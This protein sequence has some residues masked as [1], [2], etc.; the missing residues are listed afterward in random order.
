MFSR[1]TACGCFDSPSTIGCLRFGRRSRS[2]CR[3]PSRAANPGATALLLWAIFYIAAYTA[4]R[5]DLYR[6]YYTPLVA[7]MAVLAACGMGWA[8]GAARDLRAAAA[9]SA[10]GAGESAGSSLWHLALGLPMALGA[11]VYLLQQAAVASPIIKENIIWTNSLE[12]ARADCARAILERSYSGDVICT[13]AIGIV[14]WATRLPIY[15]RMGLVTKDAVNRDLP[16]QLAVSNARWCVLETEGTTSTTARIAEGYEHVGTFNRG[17]KISFLLYEKTGRNESPAPDPALLADTRDLEL[18]NGLAIRNARLSNRTIRFDLIA[19]RPCPRDYK[20]FV[21]IYRKDAPNG[22]IL[23]I[24][25]FYPMPATSKLTVGTPS[26]NMIM[27]GDD[28]PSEGA[29]VRLGL[30]DELDPQYAPLA[31]ADG[32]IDIRLIHDGS[33]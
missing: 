20:I 22:D 15:D 19:L 14:G 9:S 13:G 24:R 8:W 5:I 17:M 4:Y 2:V 29:I 30:F 16:S 1:K 27:L 6:W 12:Q 32:R 18:A 21:H 25:D 7:G 31:C 23:K 28:L 11:A 10:N 26:P 3:S 33:K